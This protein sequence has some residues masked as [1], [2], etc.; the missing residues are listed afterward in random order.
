[1]I[2]IVFYTSWIINEFD[3]VVY[4]HYPISTECNI[5]VNGN[6][7]L[8]TLPVT[9]TVSFRLYDFNRFG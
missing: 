7:G 9:K 1:M 5:I 2:S 4:E 8:V 3:K 6:I